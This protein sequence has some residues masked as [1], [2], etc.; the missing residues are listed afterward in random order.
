MRY[1]TFGK[2]PWKVSAL[3]FGCMRLPVL[4][5]DAS[6]IDEPEATR[7]VRHAIDQ[8]VN[9]IDT[10]YPYH[11][12]GS[13]VFLGRALKD[14]YREKVK[15][16][17]KLPMW[18]LKEPSDAEKYFTE[19]LTRLQD[20]YIDFY[21]LHSLSG[22]GWRKTLEL[23]VLDWAERALDDGRIG[24][25]GFSFHDD[26]AAFRQI[27]DDYDG[28]EFCQIQY[29]YMD[30]TY[31]AGAEG[32]RYASAHGL[33]VVVMEPLLGGRLAAPEPPPPVRALLDSVPAARRRTP[34]DW[35]L[36]WLWNQPEVAVVLS[37]MST[38]AQVEENLASASSSGPGTLGA[39]DLALIGAVR[40]EYRKLAPIPCTT[41]G[42][43]VPCAHGVQVPEHFRQYNQACMYATFEPNRRFY[44]RAE[45]KDRA[46]ACTQCG[47]CEE[48]CPQKLSIREL[49]AEVH[50]VF[51]EGKEPRGR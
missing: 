2:L 21:L 9:Y 43:C 48:K 47:D 12:G 7:M 32:L 40:E 31:Q 33:P 36:Q 37:G 38:M 22:K 17:T 5:G 19:Q 8:G 45:A 49:L 23:G 42:Y 1:R 26:L 25:L 44:A 18:L 6:R 51:G 24:H 39:A 34:A 15:L 10:A 41:C 28:W 27:I 50:A 16:A 29:N 13:E 46:D 4:D 11:R 35:A 3:G 14:G 20:D 30:I